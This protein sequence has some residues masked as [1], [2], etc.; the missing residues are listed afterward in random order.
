MLVWIMYGVVVASVVMVGAS[1]SL[2]LLCYVLC[3]RLVDT[4][5]THLLKKLVIIAI[6]AVNSDE[7]RTS[8]ARNPTSLPEINAGKI[9]GASTITARTPAT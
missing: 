7:H 3:G 1:I 8:A 2:L 4:L 5:V 9:T 6:I